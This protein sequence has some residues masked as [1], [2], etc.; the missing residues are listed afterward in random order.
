MRSLLYTYKKIK[1]TQTEQIIYE[2]PIIN[3]EDIISEDEDYYDILLGPS[4]N[5]DNILNKKDDKNIIQ[6]DKNNLNK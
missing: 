4:M 3:Y 6:N 2:I 1:M 5:L